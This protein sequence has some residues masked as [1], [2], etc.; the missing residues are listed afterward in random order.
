VNSLPRAVIMAPSLTE[1]MML[2]DVG[3]EFCVV[4]SRGRR[5]TQ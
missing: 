5:W 1:F 4:L 3:F 2:S